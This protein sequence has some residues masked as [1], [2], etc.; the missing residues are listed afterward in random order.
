MKRRRCG[1]RDPRLQIGLNIGQLLVG[2]LFNKV[3]RFAA[4]VVLARSLSASDFGLVNVGIA[5]SG[6]VLVASS[7]GLPDLGARDAAVAPGHAGWLAGRVAVARLI[8]VGGFSV[9]GITLASVVWPGHTSLLIMAALMAIFMA[10]SS[11]WLARGL[12]RMS[13]VAAASAAGGLTILVASFAVAELSRTATAALGAF[14]L[15]EFV[16]ALV[17]WTN[18][19]LFANAELGVSGMRSMLRRAWPLAL[20]SLAI[21]TYYANIDTIILAATHSN[22][23]AGLYS[24]PYRLFLVL[25]LVGVF[26]AYAM[27]P[28]L[29]RVTAPRTNAAADHLVLSALSPLAGYG[30]I[31]LGLVEVGGED[32]LG[33]LF[34]AP[35]RAASDAFILLA[36]GVAW[37]AVGYPAGYSLVARGENARFLWGAATASIVSIGLD[38]ALIPTLGM[39]GA[40]LATMT[41]FAA[42]ALVWLWARGL[43]R[44]GAI[45]LLVALS[46]T[47]GLAAV[48]V[49]T[50]D[51]VRVAGAGTLCMA[52]VLMLSGARGRL[53][54]VWTTALRRRGAR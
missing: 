14:A 48:V 1:A 53:S 49:F 11:D 13:V 23:E 15:A 26:A 34:G 16:A 10:I 5:I 20:S 42:A 17:L 41:A 8:V 46:A 33:A 4:F 51:S 2:E 29:A 9:I 35:F 44:R 19:D 40:A 54:H 47:S 52:I 50:H 7:V 21:Y 43:L 25:N 22:R 12:E 28:A 3:L 24:A 45:P 38:F 6:T 36:A 32:A 37:Y 39:S 31:T 30:L 27:L 18:L